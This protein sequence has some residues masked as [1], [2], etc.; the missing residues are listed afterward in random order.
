MYVY[1]IILVFGETQLSFL[2]HP[3]TK[4]FITHCGYNSFLEAVRAGVPIVG[5][6]LF[7]DQLGNG[8]KAVRHG[9]GLSLPK[10]TMKNSK[11]M[12][13]AIKTVL[14]TPRYYKVRCKAP[15]FWL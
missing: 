5:V 1:V 8:L 12:T 7:A 15:Y 9:I 6:P 11:K 13:H 2:D 4:L 14:K 3:K 10:D